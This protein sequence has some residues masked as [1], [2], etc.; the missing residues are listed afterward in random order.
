MCLVLGG[1]LGDAVYDLG[2]PCLRLGVA[3][4]SCLLVP[5]SER[6]W[7]GMQHASGPLVR[8]GSRAGQSATAARQQGLLALPSFEG[9]Q[10][11]FG[12]A[13]QKLAPVARRIHGRAAGGRPASA[14]RSLPAPSRLLPAV[15]GSWAGRRLPASSAPRARHRHLPDVWGAQHGEPRVSA[16]PWRATSTADRRGL[17]CRRRMACLPCRPSS[18]SRWAQTASLVR[19]RAFSAQATAGAAADACPAQTSRASCRR[20]TGSCC[21]STSRPCRACATTPAATRA[22]WRRSVTS[23]ATCTTC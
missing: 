6:S 5:G 1:D 7:A 4:G 23:R 15:R 20:S 17:P 16:L 21:S 8:F 14:R 2:R 18:C 10:S 9:L 19:A 11:C 13:A 12:R 3:G 22:W